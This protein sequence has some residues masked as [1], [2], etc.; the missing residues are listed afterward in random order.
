MHWIY[1]RLLE[2][3][4]SVLK[5]LMKM[6][7]GGSGCSALAQAMLDN[8]RTRTNCFFDPHDEKFEPIPATASFLEPLLLGELLLLPDK[9]DLIAAAKR[10]VHRLVDQVQ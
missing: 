2:Q 5:F 6:A 8:L 1:F 3:M 7:V 9:A 4:Q 10:C